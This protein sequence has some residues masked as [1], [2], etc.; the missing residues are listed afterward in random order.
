M[1][2]GV[3]MATLAAQPFVKEKGAAGLAIFA[4][5]MF[6]TWENF[7]RAHVRHQRDVHQA[8]GQH[9]ARERVQGESREQQ[10]QGAQDDG[11]GPEA[12]T[13]LH[14]LAPGEP[15][16]VGVEE[17]QQQD[18]AG[19]VLEEPEHEGHD[20]VGAVG[21]QLRTRQQL[22]GQEQHPD[23]EPAWHAHVPDVRDQGDG[24]RQGE[25]EPPQPGE[26]QEPEERVAQEQDVGK[27][28]RDV[29]ARTGALVCKCSGLCGGQTATPGVGGTRFR[30]SY[31]QGS[32]P[33]RS[34]TRCSCGGSML[35]LRG[36]SGVQGRL[37]RSGGP[38]AHGCD[39]KAQGV[40]EPGRCDEKHPGKRG[41]V[42][43]TIPP[44]KSESDTW[45]L[46]RASRPFRSVTT[47][48]PCDSVA[49]WSSPSPPSSRSAASSTP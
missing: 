37:L 41:L 5:M 28:A 35:L 2:N 25:R 24:H 6:W 32:C 34:P 22:P 46:S 10:A 30:A 15:L 29:G 12:R 23:P 36:D 48:Q 42:Y 19:V 39:G 8:A 31:R 47:S 3:K 33:H 13:R 26:P 43:M 49:G 38:C 9:L 16:L 21:E 44:W 17:P 7:G 14:Q 18:R 20:P 27:R 4:P 1:A 11:R 40:L 45:I